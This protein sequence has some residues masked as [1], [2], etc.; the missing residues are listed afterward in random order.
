M[1]NLQKFYKNDTIDSYTDHC[2]AVDLSGGKIIQNRDWELLLGSLSVKGAEHRAQHWD[3]GPFLLRIP[4]ILLQGCATVCQHNL[5]VGTF[6]CRMV[7]NRARI[8]DHIKFHIKLFY[9]S[10]W[11]VRLKWAWKVQSY[12]RVR[13]D[14]PERPTNSAHSWPEA[15]DSLW[16]NVFLNILFPICVG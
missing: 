15:S 4:Q 12:C 13:N 14:I 6:N 3:S 9:I 11:E 5:L 2:S 8:G 16:L 10:C 1:E 7:P